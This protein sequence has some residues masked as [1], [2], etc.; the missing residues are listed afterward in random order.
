[1]IDLIE[2]IHA[3]NDA[4]DSP[5][6]TACLTAFL[7]GF[8]LDRFVLEEIKA[9]SAPYNGNKPFGAISTYPAAWR[10]WYAAKGY[11]EHDPVY[12]MCLTT[13]RPFTWEEALI[14][15]RSAAS[16]RIMTEAA[17]FG[18]R[19]GVGLMV[20]APRG[21]LVG[22]GFASPETGL[23][24][25]MSDLSLLRSAAYHFC[26]VYADLA[27]DDRSDA[28]VVSLTDRER[29]VLLWAAAGKTK[30]QIA[31][32]L[33]V[34]ESCVK[35]HCENAFRKLEVNTLPFAVAKAIRLGL[36]HPI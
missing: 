10:E 34:G 35:R 21:L 9:R 19:S 14:E 24:F 30:A 13:F 18:L 27:A 5:G 6:L 28:P 1:M 22:F 16:E 26:H 29:E 11:A 32:L 12:R 36:I 8:E 3:T 7:G 4:K 15:Y 33:V 25:D 31:D 23:R 20:H 2:F 17:E